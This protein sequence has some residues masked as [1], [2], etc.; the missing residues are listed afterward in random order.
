MPQVVLD[1]DRKSR[2]VL[3][4]GLLLE[5]RGA[6]FTVLWN[7]GATDDVRLGTD[8]DHQRLITAAGGLRH[9]NFVDPVGTSELVRS[10][11]AQA[12]VFA[13][14]DSSK[15]VSSKDLL[16]I[17][18]EVF[19]GDVSDLWK[20]ARPTF[21]TNENVKTSGKGASLKYTWVG[22][23]P[24]DSVSADLAARMGERTVTN[25][26]TVSMEP[27]AGNA[28]RRADAAPRMADSAGGGP[29]ISEN[30][31]EGRGSAG[32]PKCGQ[33][34]PAVE[35]VQAT[36]ASGQRPENW[37]ELLGSALG[38]P[39]AAGI[40]V[41]SLPDDALQ[42]AIPALG[43]AALILQALP[44]DCKALNGIDAVQLAGPKGATALI[45]AADAELRGLESAS[46]RAQELRQAKDFLIRRLL[47]SPSVGLLR[48]DTVLRA[49]R[50]METPKDAAK[51][52]EWVVEVLAAVMSA[53]DQDSWNN[54]SLQDK[55]AA[56]RRFTS[57]PLNAT[58]SRARVLG[59]IWRNHPADLTNEMW[60][61][62]VEFD[63]LAAV[64]STPLASALES[65]AIA[66]AI[67]KPLVVKRLASATTRRQLLTS[68]AA[69]TALARLMDESD[70][71]RAFD[72]VLREDN[73]GRA[74]LVRLRNETR[75]SALTQQVERLTRHEREMTELLDEAQEA[76]RLRDDRLHRM[77][78]RLGEAA[79]STNELRES[80]S[81]QIR[82][83]VMR[84]FA[85]LCAYVDGAADSQSSQRL[86]ERI[87]RMAAR[88]GLTPA[89]VPGR[90]EPYD[91]QRHDVVGEPPEPNTPVTVTGIGYT[92]GEDADEIVLVR[93]LVERTK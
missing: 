29:I 8:G 51:N 49:T 79:A 52:R 14:L 43:R 80:Q 27:E 59:W 69:P 65:D 5:R 23:A 45:D 22:Q 10:S 72:R 76:V 86:R 56:A 75:I 74:W 93:A 63:D 87:Q 64:A 11:P 84:A 78:E 20:R 26:S 31:H 55:S 3:R 57:V 4:E 68:L 30:H 34:H 61:R 85:E 7:D 18:A 44:R 82:I 37:A 1:L 2:I 39:L 58:G 15:A 46:A 50:E 73:V 42:A 47:N 32:S 53:M 40:A 36:S 48:L 19:T 16:G 54:L 90:T 6:A 25:E 9:R 13:L 24:L 88:E 41:D 92:W 91:P 83:D 70:V 28:E 38:N 60:W 71:D 12:F 81:R 89:G 33:G 17:V 67:V 62:G 66:S 21:E 77:E 35:L